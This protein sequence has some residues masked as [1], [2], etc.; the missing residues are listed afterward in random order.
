MDIWA[1]AFTGFLPQP[2]GSV[3]SV[4]KAG[5]SGVPSKCCLPEGRRLPDMH[6]V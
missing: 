3:V 1:G 6:G 4:L 5:N 2:R